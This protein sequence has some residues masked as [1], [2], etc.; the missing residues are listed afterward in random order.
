MSTTLPGVAARPILLLADPKS[1]RET[2]GP[3]AKL[4]IVSTQKA[5]PDD[6][7]LVP[8]FEKTIPT[9]ARLV[10]PQTVAASTMVAGCMRMLELRPARLMALREAGE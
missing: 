4:P 5:F 1:S 9:D 6:A 3:V 10:L 7:I 8:E 2:A